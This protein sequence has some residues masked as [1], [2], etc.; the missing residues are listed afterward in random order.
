MD[1]KQFL[2][3]LQHQ[4]NLFLQSPRTFSKEDCIRNLK[5]CLSRQ[6]PKLAKEKIERVLS[7]F[8][9]IMISFNYHQ[10]ASL[11]ELQQVMETKKRTLIAK[12]EYDLKMK[13]LEQYY[14]RS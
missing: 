10:V 2:N 11:E 7:V 5:H 8:Q 1:R 3:Q 9:G 14:N 4:F 12:H 6:Y 13:S